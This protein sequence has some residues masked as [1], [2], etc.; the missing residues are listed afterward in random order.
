MLTITLSNYTNFC[1]FKPFSKFNCY[2]QTVALAGYKRPNVTVAMLAGSLTVSGVVDA[3]NRLPHLA[4]AAPVRIQC[5]F[6]DNQIK[7]QINCL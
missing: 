7:Q 3:F 4:K 2:N 1:A 6:G 5:L